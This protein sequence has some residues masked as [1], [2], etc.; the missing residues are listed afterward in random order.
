MSA[1][2][3]ILLNPW[4]LVAVQWICGAVVIVGLLVL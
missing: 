1:W 2:Q 4:T 3:R